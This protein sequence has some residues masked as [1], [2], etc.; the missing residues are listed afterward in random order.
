MAVRSIAWDMPGALCEECFGVVICLC[1]HILRKRQ[2][3]S[4]CICRAGQHAQNLRQRGQHLLRAH[5]AIPVAAHRPKAIVNRNILSVFGF[6]LLQDGRDI[7]AGEE[8]TFDYAMS[9]VTDYDEFQCDCGTPNCR[10]MFR[11]S[12]WR[13]PELW[14]RYAGYFSPYIQRRIERLE[15]GEQI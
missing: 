3:N 10:G 6:Q 5:N 11:G 8:I 15:R 13:R 9:D 12:D 1:L 14:E 4:A 7:A 2:G